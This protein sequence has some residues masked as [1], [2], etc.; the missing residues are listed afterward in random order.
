MKNLIR[1][2]LVA[3]LLLTIVAC[4]NIPSPTSYG[5]D[6]LHSRGPEMKAIQFET[7]RPLEG[8]TLSESMLH[9]EVTIQLLRDDLALIKLLPKEK[10]RVVGATDDMECAQ[11][12][13]KKLSRRRADAVIEWLVTQGIPASQ[14]TSDVR[15]PY[16][17]VEHR[18]TEGDRRVSRRVDI[19]IV[20]TDADGANR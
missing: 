14:L 2:H 6:A 10:F 15:G 13:C 5:P 11:D 19:E 20:V 12:A 1:S 16:M 3:S 17:G 18:Y 4:S 8:G 7:G 9:P